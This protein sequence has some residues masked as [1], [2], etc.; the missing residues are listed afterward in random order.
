MQSSIEDRSPVYL[1]VAKDG[2]LLDHAGDP[3]V[4]GIDVSSDNEPIS[5]RINFLNGLLPLE[6][7]PM[8]LQWMQMESG[9]I[10]DVYIIPG[11]DGDHILLLD[12]TPEAEEKKLLQQRNN[13]LNLLRHRF[14]DAFDQVIG[15]KDPESLVRKLLGLEESGFSRKEIS[16]LWLGFSIS[17]SDWIDHSPD[18]F[19]HALTRSFSSVIK[20]ITEAGGFLDGLYG[21]SVVG[22]FGALPISGSACEQAVLAALKSLAAVRSPEKVESIGDTPSL[23]AKAAISFGPMITGFLNLVNSRT[24]TIIGHPMENA[25]ELG[26]RAGPGEIVIDEPTYLNA[27]IYRDRFSRNLSINLTDSSAESVFTMAPQ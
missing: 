16:I 27:G 18:I 23:K 9:V 22:V 14:S 2:R 4:Y 19:V 12:S 21:D 8:Y 1:L 3:T 15:P 5:S 10:A 24:L 11:G 6:E 7:E 17:D 25:R 26:R 20:S 13:E